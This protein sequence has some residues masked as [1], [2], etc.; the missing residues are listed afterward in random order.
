MMH[1]V[2]EETMVI[3]IFILKEFTTV[4]TG[5][6]LSYDIIINDR[7]RPFTTTVK[8]DFHYSVTFKTLAHSTS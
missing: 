8:K 4:V 7:S 2:N 5:R 3:S 1:T 6:E